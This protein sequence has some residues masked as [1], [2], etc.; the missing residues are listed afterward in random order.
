MQGIAKSKIFGFQIQIRSFSKIRI[1]NPIQIH[2]LKMDLNPKKSKNLDLNPSKKSK[3]PTKRR[4][5]P[6][7]IQILFSKKGSESKSNPKKWISNPKKS[8]PNQ[9]RQYPASKHFF[10]LSFF[11]FYLEVMARERL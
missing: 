5:N 8:N 7:Q 1:S 10:F 3:N 11:P 6:I 4:K 2:I 9:I